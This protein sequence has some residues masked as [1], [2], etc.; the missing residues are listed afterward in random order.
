[1]IGLCLMYCLFL[2]SLYFVLADVVN[3]QDEECC[4]ITC[5]NTHIYDMLHMKIVVSF[6]RQVWNNN[7]SNNNLSVRV[8][9]MYP[10]MTRGSAYNAVCLPQFSPRNAIKMS[11]CYTD[12]QIRF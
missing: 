7:N 1:M 3:R 8:R 10:K 4:K 12:L 9:N 6:L 11:F 5:S 2:C